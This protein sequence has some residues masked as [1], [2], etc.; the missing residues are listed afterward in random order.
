MISRDDRA[1]FERF[2]DFFTDRIPYI[3]KYNIWYYTIIPFFQ[4]VFRKNHTS[5]YELWDLY[6]VLSKFIVRK[7]KAFRDSKPQGYPSCFSDWNSSYEYGGI[8][9]TK[10]EYDKQKKVGFYTGGGYKAWLKTLDEMIFAFEFALQYDSLSRDV[11]KIHFIKKYHLKNPFAKISKN[12]HITYTYESKNGNVFISDKPPEI[13]PDDKFLGKEI[14]YHDYKADEEN[15]DR[16]NKA[17]ALFSKHF[18][19]LWS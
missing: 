9:L 7:L 15:Y 3:V 16:F 8:G 10:K 4:K 19:S 17:I 12:K 14:Y 13:Y 2:I 18:L 5:D 11:K 1:K 6:P